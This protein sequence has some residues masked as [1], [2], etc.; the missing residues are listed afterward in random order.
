MKWFRQAIA[1]RRC[2]GRVTNKQANTQ[3]D[4]L[5]ILPSPNALLNL[6]ALSNKRECK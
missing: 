2:G 3:A 1:M 6:A 5:S 4:G